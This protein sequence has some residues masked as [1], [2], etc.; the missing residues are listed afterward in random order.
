MTFCQLCPSERLGLKTKV[1]L[2]DL[3]PHA[4]CVSA[5]CM[6]P[7]PPPVVCKLCYTDLQGHLQV[8]NLL[9]QQCPT[10]ATLKN[11]HSKTP[12]ECLPP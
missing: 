11:R 8:Y 5:S 1:F 6:P 9:A 10:A 2:N 12:L 7:C 4:C 3:R